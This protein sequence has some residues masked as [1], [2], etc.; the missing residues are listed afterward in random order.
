MQEASDKPEKGYGINESVAERLRT[1]LASSE[2]KGAFLIDGPWGSGKTYFIEDFREKWNASD[3]KQKMLYVSLNGLATKREIDDALFAATH[4]II[5]AAA[6]NRFARL[7]MHIAKTAAS[8]FRVGL[9]L[10]FKDSKDGKAVTFDADFSNLPVLRDVFDSVKDGAILVF[11]DL[12]RCKLD[13]ASLLGYI[14]QFIEQDHCKV[15]LLA[16]EKEIERYH[17]SE[18]TFRRALLAVLHSEGKAMG[19]EE[20]K[21]AMESVNSYL[22]T[23]YYSVIKEKVVADEAIL[24]FD[25]QAALNYFLKEVG[26][27]KSV[28]LSDIRELIEGHI[29][30]IDNWRTLFFIK[31]RL[32][33][34]FL[35]TGSEWDF[36]KD[37]GAIFLIADQ[38]TKKAILY[39]SGSAES[40]LDFDLYEG[41]YSALDLFVENEVFVES[42]VKKMIASAKQIAVR[43]NVPEA[44]T[45][46]LTN[47]FYAMSDEEYS[48]RVE[49]LCGL[50]KEGEI[51]L[52]YW[53][54]ILRVL[55]QHKDILGTYPRR[56]QP[57]DFLSKAK[58]LL[59]DIEINDDDLLIYDNP[60]A[61]ISEKHGTAFNQLRQLVSDRKAQSDQNSISD[62]AFLSINGTLAEKAI[63]NQSFLTAIGKDKIIALLRKGNN[64]QLRSFLTN[65]QRAYGISNYPDFLWIDYPVAHAVVQ[66]I[67]SLLNKRGV[68]CKNLRKVNLI[69]I[70]TFLIPVERRLKA[71]YVF[72]RSS[73]GED[74]PM[75]AQDSTITERPNTIEPEDI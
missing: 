65:L 21:H 7:G 52:L 29:E 66:E 26:E 31:N 54:T 39:R 53:P 27:S 20:F 68:S 57:R 73:I 34:F 38:I 2:T 46:F 69:A 3:P 72:Q 51:G 61:P 28:P 1:Y 37:S 50:F 75:T 24:S 13:M 17:F 18:E 71:A 19:E 58:E 44:I 35:K 4:P 30:R 23:P 64:E 9:N 70:K 10:P 12:E 48:R 14:S 45:P 25:R 5:K 8:I 55:F 40:V 36:S 74:D 15:I 67:D 11:D 60:P 56:W 43:E 22:G 16:C 49:N 41:V 63:A 59:E 32:V 42:E 6:D 47:S 33:S 62:L